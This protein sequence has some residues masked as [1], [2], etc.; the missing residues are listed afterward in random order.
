[1]K[2]KLKFLLPSLLVFFIIISS[3]NL[4]FAQEDTGSIDVYIQYNTFEKT[5]TYA[6]TLKV[7]QD[8]NEDPFVVI[9]FP[10]SNPIMIDS[11][12]LG[13][14]YKVEVYVNGMLGNSKKIDVSGNEE[15]EIIIPTAGGMLFRVLYN[16]GSTTVV[17]ATVSIF[18]DDTQLWAQDTTDPNGKTTRF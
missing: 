17:G 16:D 12:P 9:G 11:L 2:N 13:H 15:M 14:K 18:S 10:E 3:A 4:S 7:Y 6:L 5:E 8:N 1:M